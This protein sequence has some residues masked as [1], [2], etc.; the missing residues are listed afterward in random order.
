MNQKLKNF[1][2]AQDNIPPGIEE[3]RLLQKMSEII[4]EENEHPNGLFCG[5]F[6]NSGSYLGLSWYARA[7]FG[8]NRAIAVKID[9]FGGRADIGRDQFDPDVE[10]RGGSWLSGAALDRRIE[11]EM[12][13]YVEEAIRCEIR[14]TIYEI[15]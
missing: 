6:E 7:D 14:S 10:S 4:F 13:L 12:R 2:L 8:R 15:K 1:I 11:K 3:E 9:G 5:E